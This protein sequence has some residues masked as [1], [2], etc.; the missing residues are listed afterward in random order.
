MERIIIER[1]VE[2]KRLRDRSRSIK[3]WNRTRLV[4][5]TTPLINMCLH[6]AKN[7][8]KYIKHQKILK[9]ASPSAECT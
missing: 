2:D 1:K 8:A 9:L 7:I 6:D 4:D 3:Y 5:Q